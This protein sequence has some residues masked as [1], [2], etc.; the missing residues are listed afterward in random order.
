MRIE[1]RDPDHATCL[2]RY[3]TDGVESKSI[4]ADGDEFH[5]NVVFDTLEIEDGKHLK[6]TGGRTHPS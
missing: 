4:G 3:P 6:S 1:Q 2:Q 5:S